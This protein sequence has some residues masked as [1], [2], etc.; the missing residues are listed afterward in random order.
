MR[1]HTIRTSVFLTSFVGAQRFEGRGATLLGK[2]RYIRSMQSISSVV[3]SVRISPALSWWSHDSHPH[4]QATHCV[5]TK[6]SHVSG[7][8]FSSR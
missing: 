2:P 8:A 1:S 5:R 3:C 6:L 7:A 4:S